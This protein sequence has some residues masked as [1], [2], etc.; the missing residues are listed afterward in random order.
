[1]S[2]TEPVCNPVEIF[3]NEWA[4][5]QKLLDCNY[6]FHHEI[7]SILKTFICSNYTDRAFS[8]L[9]LGCGDA[10]FTIKAVPVSQL[11]RY[12]G[13]DL[14]ETALAG[15]AQNLQQLPNKPELING[16]LLDGVA[17]ADT[18]FDLIFS[19]YA[20][21]HLA[22]DAK[23]A[24]FRHAKRALKPG[25]ILCLVDVMRENGQDRT[26]YLRSYLRFAETNWSALIAEELQVISA[27][28]ESHDFPETAA[29][30]KETALSAG[31]TH[32]TQLAHY[33]W[34]QAW[35]FET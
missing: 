17:C 13:H 18:E 35:C 33:T 6:M 30:Y 12:Q 1:V 25:G 19:S 32:A 20:L 26:D 2:T 9:E 21:H 29:W 8:M 3:Q 23:Q 10:S 4:I 5:Y 14:S 16:D 27:H 11:V 34:H 31:F 7:Y 28:V 15:A 24:F 22:T